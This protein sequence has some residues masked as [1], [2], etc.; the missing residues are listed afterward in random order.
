MRIRERL[1]PRKAILLTCLPIVF[2]ATTA[3]ACI[4]EERNV[5][6]VPTKL[7]L[8]DGEHVDFHSS[9]YPEKRTLF[10]S[11]CFLTQTTDNRCWPSNMVWWHRTRVML[12]DWYGTPRYVPY[13]MGW[14]YRA[15]K[16]WVELGN[17]VAGHY[18]WG[19]CYDV[20]GEK[21]WWGADPPLGSGGSI[22]PG[23]VV[24]DDGVPENE[25]PGSAARRE[26]HDHTQLQDQST[27]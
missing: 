13:L 26:T 16:V 9:Q 12:I 2:L 8:I 7:S 18:P 1:S 23:V 3:E 21:T 25:T 24:P 11:F 27:S 5:F 6:G 14:E 19:P 10:E 15:C 17:F 20:Y 4:V 22:L